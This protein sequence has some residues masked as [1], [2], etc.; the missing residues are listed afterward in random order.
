MKKLFALSIALFLMTIGFA[1]TTDKS[2]ALLDEVSTKISAYKN[3]QIS[4]DYSLDN[5]KE[6]VHQKTSGTVNIQGQKY[7]LNFMGV[8]KIYDLKKVYTIVHEDEEVVI[9]NPT[10]EES[11]FS[12]SN[13]LSFYKKGYKY[14]WDKAATI[15]GKKIQYIKLTPIKAGDVTY[16]MLGIDTQNKQIYQVEYLDKKNT[17]TTLKIKSFKPNVEMS[18]K[19]FVFDE[20][21]YKDKDYTITRM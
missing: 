9:S 20:T 21:K 3:I 8:E 17:K 16:I 11:E 6:K 14:T 5:D 1:Q 19:E 2:K 12:P 10:T 7:H 18:P 15:E 4:F 13:I